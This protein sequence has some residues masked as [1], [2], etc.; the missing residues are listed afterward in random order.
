MSEESRNFETQSVD[1]IAASSI[2]PSVRPRPLIAPERDLRQFSR[3]GF[4][5]SFVLVVKRSAPIRSHDHRICVK[6]R[7]THAADDDDDLHGCPTGFLHRKWE[8][9]ICCLRDVILKVEGNFSNN[10]NKTSISGVKLRWTTLYFRDET[11]SP[12]SKPYYSPFR[13]LGRRIL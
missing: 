5:C 10:I 4:G 2:H 8:Y 9:S 6:S 1:A 3:G 12:T 13:L 11:S 7:R